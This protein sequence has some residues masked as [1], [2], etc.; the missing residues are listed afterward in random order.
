MG[1]CSGT[2]IFDDVLD[3]VLN[4]KM[5]K[6]DQYDVVLHLAKA[7]EDHDWDCQDESRH[8][9]HKLVHRAFLELNPDWDDD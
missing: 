9:E 2:Q 8:W 6:D 7:L 4:S 3:F 1:F 5:S